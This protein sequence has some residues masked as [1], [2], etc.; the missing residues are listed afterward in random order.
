M[1]YEY[2][3]NPFRKTFGNNQARYFM[4]ALQHNFVSTEQS[5]N[6]AAQLLLREVEAM[7][8]DGQPRHA[9]AHICDTTGI[10]RKQ[11]S[12]FV[13]ELQS[14]VFKSQG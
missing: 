1:R 8:L 6:A 13:A 12:D 11:A 5:D 7:L 4:S 9:I 2:S 10:D 3:R 14:G